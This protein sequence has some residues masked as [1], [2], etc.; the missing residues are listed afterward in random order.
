MS[1]SRDNNADAASEEERIITAVMA[2]LLPALQ[3]LMVSHS[4][5]NASSSTPAPATPAPA[6]ATLAPATLAPATPATLAPATPATAVVIS[7][8]AAASSAQQEQRQRTAPTHRTDAS[9]RHPAQQ[10]TA[11][12][13]RTADASVRHPA[14]A[15]YSGLTVPVDP[16]RPTS[17]PYN[18]RPPATTT[19]ATTTATYAPRPLTTTPPRRAPG[20]TGGGARGLYYPAT[21]TTTDPATTRPTISLALTSASTTQRQQHRARAAMQHALQEAARSARMASELDTKLDKL[22]DDPE[23]FHWWL[24]QLRG[25]LQHEA[26]HN[27]LAGGEPYITG[28]DK[29]GRKLSN[30]LCQ[31]L[32]A[33]MSPAV[34]QA[35]GG[36]YH[37][38][39]GLGME[40]LQVLMDHFIPSES[41]NLP[42]IFTE[43]QDLHQR[44]NELATVFSGRITRLAARSKR[45]GQEYVEVSKILTFITGLHAGFADFA[46]DYQSGRIC[47]SQT[48]LR[49]TTALAKTLERTMHRHY[50]FPDTLDD[51]DDDADARNLEPLSD[52]QV[53]ELFENF[54]CPLC[55]TDDHD[56]LD[57]PALGD[58]G[59][60]ISELPEHSDIMGGVNITERPEDPDLMGGVGIRHPES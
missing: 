25:R 22:S 24:G 34:Y 59:F 19:A 47:L 32:G 46:K 45:A 10:R 14:H 52:E 4:L 30:K 6:P 5:N 35:I 2:R 53:T 56:F 3:D 60:I 57:C 26:W 40:L 58:Q 9:V 55:R 36:I 18:A 8:H 44:P 28:P 33:C 11:P 1:L 20:V 21:A 29:R 54:D 43:W 42:M 7:R 15:T 23:E 49:E 17:W 48:T 16:A 12:T 37:L 38:D 13:H 50:Y 39:T 31:L 41:V 51:D 27:I